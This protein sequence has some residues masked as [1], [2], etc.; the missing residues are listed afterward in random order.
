M[1]RHKWWS[2]ITGLLVVVIIAGGVA[3]WARYPV[4]QPLEITSL[5]QEQVSGGIYISGAVAI[6]GFYPLKTGDRIEDLI[7]AAGGTSGGA[8]FSRIELNV[9]SSGSRQ[10]QKLD[11]NRAESWLL[12]ALP[13][14][15]ETRAQAII[16]YRSRNGLFRHTYELTRVEGIGTGLYDRIKNLISVN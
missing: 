7:Q 12:Q 10:P 11:I 3:A 2:L 13:G 16:D 1:T 5:Q 15:G 8:D 14:I 9:P 6:P 4:S